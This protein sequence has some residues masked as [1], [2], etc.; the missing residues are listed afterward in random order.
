[1]EKLNSGIKFSPPPFPSASSIYLFLACMCGCSV[2]SDLV[3]PPIFSVHGSFQARILEWVAISFSRGASW[4]RDWTLV[5]CIGRRIIY[6][7]ASW[8]AP[9]RGSESPRNKAKCQGSF[10]GDF[11]SLFFSWFT[12]FK[13]KKTGDFPSGPAAKALPSQCR[14][15]RFNPCSGN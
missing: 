14:R 10:S 5:S 11:S 4:C 8:E 15:P 1:M 3:T 9:E 2:V 6:H 7:W 13:N 12:S